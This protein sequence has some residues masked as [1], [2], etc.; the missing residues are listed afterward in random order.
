MI[1][2]S[3]RRLRAR[4]WQQVTCTEG[5]PPADV[6][7]LVPGRL[8]QALEWGEVLVN[9]RAAPINPA[10]VGHSA[11]PFDGRSNILSATANRSPVN[12][13]AELCHTCVLRCP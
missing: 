13:H 11:V 3:E 7:H 9:I 4:L 10:D 2:M 6:L 8:P 5:G 1:V 12:M